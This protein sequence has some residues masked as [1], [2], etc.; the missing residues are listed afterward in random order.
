[1]SF[2][3]GKFRASRSSR[4]LRHF[5]FFTS[6]SAIPID[7]N[8]SQHESRRTLHPPRDWFPLREDWNWDQRL[9]RQ[10][11]DV[12]FPY[13]SQRILES[14]LPVDLSSPLAVYFREIVA[15]QLWT[16]SAIVEN[17]MENAIKVPRG[18]AM[19]FTSAFFFISRGRPITKRMLNLIC[20]CQFHSISRII[21][22][23]LS[24]Q[25]NVSIVCAFSF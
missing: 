21:S 8:I 24:Q 10:G 9:G 13:K 2:R 23:A 4:L 12:G 20:I 22:R 7:S 17:E 15:L 25:R 16:I 5:L 18:F 11:K 19:F 6:S 3:L 1:M 14:H